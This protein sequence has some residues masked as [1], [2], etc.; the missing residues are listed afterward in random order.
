[1]KSQVKLS[2]AILL[3][4]SAALSVGLVSAQ[5]TITVA[6]V[7]DSITAG[8]GLTNSGTQSYPAQLQTL[9][10]SG[11]TVGNYGDSGTTVE[12]VSDYTYWNSWAYTNSLN[13]SPNIVVIMFGANDSKSWN[14]NAS[15][16]NS[17]YRALIALFQNL[18]SNPKVYVCYTPPMYL[19]TAFG[20]TFDP[21][22]IENTVEPAL[23]VIATQAAV[24]LIDNDTPLINRPD[25][26]QDGVHPT[27]AGA[28]I[29]AQQVY[30]AIKGLAPTNITTAAIASSL[31]PSIQGKAVTYTATLSSTAGTPTGSVV[32]TVGNTPFSTNTLSGGTA[33][34]T[35]S[36]VPVG[37]TNVVHAQ[38][39][40]QGSYIG[41][42]HSLYQNVTAS[43]GVTLTDIGS[44]P[45]PGTNDIYQL[46]TSGNTTW[47]DGINYFTD[48]NPPVGQTF[49]TGTNATKL[50][51]VAIKTAGLNSGN[52]Y[53]TPTNTPTY[54]L[55]IYSMSNTTATLLVTVSAPNPG[56]TDGDWL[57][58]TGLNVTLATNKTYAFSFGI[59]PTGGGW[60]ALAVATNA[61]A[62]GEI[63]II[64][65]SGGTITTGS[66]HKFD[67]V[68][69]LGLSAAATNI[70]ASMPWPNPTYGMN[71]GNTLE[72]YQGPPNVALF[73]SA[74][75][76]GFNAV[77]IPCGWDMN[78]TTN[79]T[80]NATNYL[81][82]SAYMAQ[83]KQA[84]D[85]AIAAGMYAMIN[86]HWDDGWLENNIGTNV[87]PIINA[88]MKLVLGTDC[89]QLCRL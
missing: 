6:C 5:A 29:V 23:G 35:N 1:M 24:Q 59:Q 60:A 72:L 39:L 53:G 49:T 80:A 67:A 87:D 10:G 75:Q 88:K 84:V 18:P 26:F 85:G 37:S 4:I 44:A 41:S 38:Y 21:V 56:F 3:A 50:V 65:I 76:N 43:A 19:P 71:V 30:N 9:L 12:K 20:A 82:K 46:S 78:A 81:I 54:Y 74:V 58:W 36:S 47:P 48:N 66:S 63:A 27:V 55:R 8:Y 83:V 86:D 14:W 61:Y 25:L 69:D 79:I 73:Y 42:T 77:R 52:G 11:Y 51:S 57:K 22:F 34:T 17:D 7:G 68:F 15:N 28:A 32:F 2:F 45:S 33:S 16:F 70:P 64:P 62:G 31:N 89:H 13:S 40:G